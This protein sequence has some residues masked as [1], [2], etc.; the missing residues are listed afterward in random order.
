MGNAGTQVP[1]IAY[2]KGVTPR[3]AVSTDLIDFSDFLP[4]LL[5]AG[6]IA[7][8]G[9]LELDGRS[10]LP[11]IRGE[12]ADPRRWVFCH[13]DPMVPFGGFQLHA[14]RWARN[15]RFKLYEDGRFYDLVRDPLEKHAMQSGEV[16]GDAASA[17]ALLEE[18]HGSMPPWVERGA[19]F[20]D[21]EQNKKYLKELQN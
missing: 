5:E 14:G 20:R 16:L 18:V 12:P 15:Q 7:P 2:W 17:K 19:Q 10:F 3:G 8:P 9:P 13:Y 4:T 11:Q 21:S 1:L 6:R